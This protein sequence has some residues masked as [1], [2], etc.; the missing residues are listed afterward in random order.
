MLLGRQQT[1]E[2]V[3]KQPAFVIP[4][5]P[6]PARAAGPP[7]FP[8]W[9]QRNKVAK[10]ILKNPIDKFTLRDRTT[11]NRVPRGATVRVQQL[12]DSYTAH[13]L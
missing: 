6:D 13:L 8:I 11:S 3:R 12:K 7:S 5:A 1:G 10:S 4:R 9:E 2:R